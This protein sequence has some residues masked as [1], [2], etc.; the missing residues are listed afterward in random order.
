MLYGHIDEPMNSYMSKL[1]IALPLIKI[2]DKQRL[3]SVHVV[4]EF[5]VKS[6]HN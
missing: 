6:I 5:I 1:T 4:R 3:F 2:Q